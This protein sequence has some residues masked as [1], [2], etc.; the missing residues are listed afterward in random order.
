[1]KTKQKQTKKQKG[2][3]R[4]REKDE[5]CADISQSKNH[6][7]S[8][9]RT[10]LYSFDFVVQKKANPGKNEQKAVESSIYTQNG[11]FLFY[12]LIKND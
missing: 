11:M 5:N 8:H 9:W 4:K 2:K 3:H 1:M 12:A 7:G 10:A 6:P